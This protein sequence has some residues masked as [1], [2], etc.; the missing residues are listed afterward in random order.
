MID[1]EI[2]DSNTRAEAAEAKVANLRSLVD[3]LA[4][5]VNAEYTRSNAA[6]AEVARLRETLAEALD[7][8]TEWTSSTWARF[9]AVRD[10]EELV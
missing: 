8:N 7:P 2:F 5:Q 10:G 9:L 1:D 3:S 4:K 6:E